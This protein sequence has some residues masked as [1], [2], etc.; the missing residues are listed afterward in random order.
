MPPEVAGGNYVFGLSVWVSICR[1]ICPSVI[2]FC[3]RNNLRTA[4]GIQVKVGTSMYNDAKI[5]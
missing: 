5:N 4:E 2:D 1:C 3:Y